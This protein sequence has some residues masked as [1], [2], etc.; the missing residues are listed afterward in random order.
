MNEASKELET[1]ESRVKFVQKIK[2]AL[3][4]SQLRKVV[5][6]SNGVDFVELTVG[7]T[8]T[9]AFRARVRSSSP[10]RSITRIEAD[11]IPCPPSQKCPPEPP[12]ND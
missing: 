5:E 6:A 1:H 12:G 11:G 3:D 9:G 10:D 4:L 7:V 8:N 2:F